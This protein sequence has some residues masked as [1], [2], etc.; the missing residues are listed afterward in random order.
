M[1]R[2]WRPGFIIL[3]TFQLAAATT[4]GLNLS[5][6][7]AKDEDLESYVKDCK[8]ADLGNHRVPNVVHY[9]WFGCTREFLPYHYLSVIS[10]K[11][12]KLVCWKNA[13]IFILVQC[14][15]FEKIFEN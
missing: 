7:M 12:E 1:R 3:L 14:L 2:I 8:L 10:G 6:R 15:I 4:L 5:E 11:V 13:F 9:I